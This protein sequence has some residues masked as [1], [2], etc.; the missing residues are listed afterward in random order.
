[1]PT[2]KLGAGL[3]AALLSMVAAPLM[4]EE[5]LTIQQ[6]W[7]STLKNN[8]RLRGEAS[9]VSG[10]EAGVDEAWAAVK[11]QVDFTAGY[12]R[13]WYKRDIGRGLLEEDQDNPSRL[14]VGVSQVLYSRGAFKGIGQAERS[15]ER[16]QARLDATR[17]QVGVESLLSYLEVNRLQK[18][19][20]VLDGELASH[21]Q[22]ANQVEQKLERGFATRAEALEAISR[23]D[24]VRAQLVKLKSRH[25]AALQKLQQLVGKP[26]SAVVEVNE[27]LWRQTPQF[28]TTNWQVMVLAKAPSVKVAEAESR[29]ASASYEVAVSGHYP[30]LSLNARYTDNDSFAT[31]LLEERKVELR[32]V[33]PIYKGGSTSARSRAARYRQEGAE[34]LLA[35]ERE[36]VAVEVQRLTAELSGGYNN[37]RALE[38]ALESASASEEAAN[39]GFLAGVRNL[40]GL[41][42]VRKR[43]SAIEQELINAVFDNLS[44]R[45]QLLSLADELN[46]ERLQPWGL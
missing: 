10:E 26:V 17:A 44:N 35:S 7:E 11:P 8:L 34:W 20:D 22:Q 9:Y 2:Y 4:A 32:L 30:E 3:V 38:Q 18:L 6:A 13:T 14:D 46:K 16:E 19:V 24:D 31:S 23:V 25:W 33:I 28:L 37:I 43:R 45:L 29:L 41:L 40:V 42:D 15:V 36:Q 21:Q 12:G 1:M 39:E 27:S 5:P